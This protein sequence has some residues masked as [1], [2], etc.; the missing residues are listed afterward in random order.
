[1]SKGGNRLLTPVDQLPVHALADRDLRPRGRRLVD[2][3]SRVDT[4]T[5]LPVTHTDLVPPIEG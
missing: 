3:P 5:S 4:S 1:M 2:D